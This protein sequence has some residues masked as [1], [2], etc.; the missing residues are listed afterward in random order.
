MNATEQAKYVEE[1]QA[2]QKVGKVVQFTC[3]SDSPEGWVDLSTDDRSILELA[4]AYGVKCL[5]LKPET[6]ERKP[7]TFPLS[8]IAALTITRDMWQ[9]LSEDSIRTKW[10]WVSQFAPELAGKM[11]ADCACCQYARY[12]S[13]TSHLDCGK[14]P[15]RSHWGSAHMACGQPNQ[16]FG[17]WH[18]YK[19]SPTQPTH[20]L[21]AAKRISDAAARRLAELQGKTKEESVPATTF[22]NG[23]PV[24]EAGFLIRFG[25]AVD[26]D[27]SYI[28]VARDYNGFTYSNTVTEP[29]LLHSTYKSLGP[30][31]MFSID[32]GQT[33]SYCCK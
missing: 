11:L 30:D 14:C 24:P 20:R 3:D 12:H 22:P 32:Q 10:Q 8:E 26:I 27:G 19:V 33:W 2:A 15:L 28:V 16:D 7:Y 21:A 9:W 5:R 25:Q 31:S 1:L 6:P 18:N 23:K 4:L 29:S 13:A 17:I